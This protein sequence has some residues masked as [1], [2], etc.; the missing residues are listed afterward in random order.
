MREISRLSDEGFEN[1]IK[2]F[3]SIPET[4]LAVSS[5]GSVFETGQNHAPGGLLL[6]TFGPL[7]LVAANDD[8]TPDAGRLLKCFS[9]AAAS[10]DNF[11]SLIRRSSTLAAESADG[12]PLSPLLFC[13]S[14]FAGLLDTLTLGRRFS[15]FEL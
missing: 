13:F 9:R 14:S 2:S 7:T 8:D 4:T 11:S 1:I 12:R 3:Q 5:L 10:D 6:E 15:S